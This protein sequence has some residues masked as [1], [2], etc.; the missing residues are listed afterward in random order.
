[1]PRLEVLS[2]MHRAA[3]AGGGAQSPLAPRWSRLHRPVRSFPIPP[4]GPELEAGPPGREGAGLGELQR[5][6]EM[7]LGEQQPLGS[8]SSSVQ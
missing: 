7:I 3:A 8:G 2:C 1:M 6:W 4:P 5:P